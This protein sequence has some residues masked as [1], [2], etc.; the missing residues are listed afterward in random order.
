MLFD[1]MTHPE[2]Q[3]TQLVP[4]WQ[5][6]TALNLTLF[7][8]WGQH[9]ASSQ[10]HLLFQTTKLLW[11]SSGAGNPALTILNK[12]K[13]AAK[14]SLPKLNHI[15]WFWSRYDVNPAP[16]TSLSISL[17][18][19]KSGWWFSSCLAAFLVYRNR[20]SV[21]SCTVLCNLWCRC[22]CMSWQVMHWLFSSLAAGEGNKVW[23]YNLTPLKFIRAE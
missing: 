13:S 23:G 14:M 2:E 1:Q 9:T 10:R 21:A 20:D 7:L 19:E 11:L 15:W 17:T 6:L 12:C 3:S 5:T 18:G 16:I 8:L 22:Q 4:P